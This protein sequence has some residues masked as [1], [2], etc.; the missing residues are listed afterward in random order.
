[1]PEGQRRGRF[2][3]ISGRNSVTRRACERAIIKSK[4]CLADPDVEVTTVRINIES[5]FEQFDPQL[6]AA[7]AN[8]ALQTV[9]GMTTKSALR[10]YQAFRRNAIR[11]L[12][13]WE[14]LPSTAL[15]GDTITGATPAADGGIALPP[16]S[17]SRK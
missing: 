10:L 3:L 4:L 13:P 11:S 7:L 15:T 16:V 6:S 2:Q 1:M 5:V 17:D 14:R 12:S 9:P 8:A